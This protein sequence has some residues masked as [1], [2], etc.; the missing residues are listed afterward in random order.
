[1]ANTSDLTY[2]DNILYKKYTLLFLSEW[3]NINTED[4]KNNVLQK[5]GFWK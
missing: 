4:I 1:M 3:Y 2:F 5:R